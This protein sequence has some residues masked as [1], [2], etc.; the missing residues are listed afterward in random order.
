MKANHGVLMALGRDVWRCL[1]FDFVA[2]LVSQEINLRVCCGWVQFIS[3]TPTVEVMLH[4]A[5]GGVTKNVC[6]GIFPNYI[7]ITI[8]DV[9]FFVVCLFFFIH[10]WLLTTF[11][12]YLETNRCS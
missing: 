1:L 12:I 2:W 10:I 11:S 5:L 4:L 6:Y 7:G 9:F 8:Y 3:M